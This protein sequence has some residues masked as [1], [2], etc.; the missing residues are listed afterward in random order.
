LNNQS[1]IEICLEYAHKIPN[2]VFTIL[3]FPV[4]V[5]T[6]LRRHGNQV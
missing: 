2:T 1:K 4:G 3:S 6:E 5:V